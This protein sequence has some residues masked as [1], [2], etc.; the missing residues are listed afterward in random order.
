MASDLEA[1][2]ALLWTR[3][4]RQ[5][6][7]AHFPMRP[8]LPSQLKASFGGWWLASLS[9]LIE[10]TTLHPLKKRKEECTPP[11]TVVLPRRETEIHDG[12]SSDPWPCAVCLTSWF[13]L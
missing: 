12:R 11:C 9:R 3:M 4:G 10:Y 6:D 7:S 1:Q 13:D 5:M 2:L 8:A